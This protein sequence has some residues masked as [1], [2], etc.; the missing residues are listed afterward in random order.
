M[1]SSFAA[2][3]AKLQVMGQDV[4]NMVDCSDVLP[5][6][7]PFTGQATFPAGQNHNDVEQ[8]VSLHGV[9]VLCFVFA[10]DQ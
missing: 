6:P 8:A 3:Y 10:N 9:L 5:I 4:S 2:A 7:K 1:T